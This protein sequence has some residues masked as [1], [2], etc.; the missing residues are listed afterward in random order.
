MRKCL[1]LVQV[2][3]DSRDIMR[4]AYAAFQEGTSPDRMLQAVDTR[5]PSDAFYANLVSHYFLILIKY[6][7]II[8][9]DLQSSA[10]QYS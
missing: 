9:D 7:L 2:G 3:R 6:H 10:G 1:N 5:R 8:S 4:A